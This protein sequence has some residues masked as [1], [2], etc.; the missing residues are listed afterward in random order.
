MEMTQATHPLDEVTPHSVFSGG[1]IG[2]YRSPWGADS[3]VK[4]EMP[5]MYP[6]DDAAHAAAEDYF[7][8]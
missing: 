5:A 2:E 3:T 4:A 1:W 8:N 7:D 6:D